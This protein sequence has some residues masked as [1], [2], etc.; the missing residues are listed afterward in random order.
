MTEHPPSRFVG[1]GRCRLWRLLGPIAVGIAAGITTSCASRGP[2]CCGDAIAARDG[3]PRDVTLVG[4]DLSAV[5]AAFNAQSDRWRLVALVSPTCSE[6]VLGAEAVKKE[7]TDRYRSDQVGALVI[8]IPMLEPDNEAAARASATI[9]PLGRAAQ[10]YDSEQH[11]GWAYARETFAGFRAR[12]RKAIADDH[13]LARAIDESRAE[14]PQWDLYMLYAPGVTW[15]QAPPMPTRWLR[16]FGRRENGRSLYWR[17]SPDQPPREGD[18]FL[19]IREMADDAMGPPLTKT[20]GAA[21][22]VEVLGFEGCPNTPAMLER[23][24]AA[25]AA[26]RPAAKVVYVDQ[27]GLPES[28]VRRG[29]PT[30]TVLADGRD[31]FGLPVPTGPAMGCRVYPGGVPSAEQIAARLR[32]RSEER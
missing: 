7:V 2:A 4:G 24:R 30:P 17:D 29:Y 14:R 18:L 16:H 6:C 3:V 15:T 26:I 31:L 23:A 10:F 32:D 1:P 28:D 27:N 11:V 12:A 20:G 19:A 21:M 25:A 9:F 22:R 5:R 8:W 13:P